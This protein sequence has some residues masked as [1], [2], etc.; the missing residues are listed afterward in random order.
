MS[1]DG[2]TTSFRSAPAYLCVGGQLRSEHERA[3]RGRLIAVF[4]GACVMRLKLPA[5]GVGF[6]LF[7][8]LCASI[9]PMFD[10]RTFSGLIAVLFGWPWIDFLPSAWFP[11]AIVIN[12]TIIFT[13]LVAL[14]LVPT[15]FRQSRK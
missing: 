10:R 7:A 1:D 2:N 6:Y 5:I 12:A 4:L 3:G 14:A 13:I 11:L 15:L 9:Y 8:F